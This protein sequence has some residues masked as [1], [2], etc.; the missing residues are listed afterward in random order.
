MKDKILCVAALLICNV[1]AEDSIPQN[2]ELISQTAYLKSTLFSGL[3]IIKN[4]QIILD[5]DFEL[6]SKKY[7]DSYLL[8][9]EYK[10]NKTLYNVLS[11]SGIILMFSSLAF[12]ATD[13]AYPYTPAFLLGGFITATISIPFE[14]KSNNKLLKCVWSYNNNIYLS[15]SNNKMAQ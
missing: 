9:K 2:N 15:N 6:L 1:F 7:I 10:F 11:Y 4:N 13:H 14:I 8:F 3:V 12:V 5:N